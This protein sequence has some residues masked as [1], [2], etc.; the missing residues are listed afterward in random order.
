MGPG[1]NLVPLSCGSVVIPGIFSSYTARDML[2]PLMARGNWEHNTAVLIRGE[3][4]QP[5]SWNA[6]KH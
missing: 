1:A 6:Q 2:S 4:C 3:V 5:G